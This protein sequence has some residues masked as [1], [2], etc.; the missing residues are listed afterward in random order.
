[1]RFLDAGASN[2][3]LSMKCCLE[4]TIKDR[5]R[6]VLLI[7]FTYPHRRSALQF[8]LAES[9]SGSEGPGVYL[10][11]TYLAASRPATFNQQNRVQ[12]SQ[13]A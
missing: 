3:T 5:R 1:M 9:H 13:I 6:F 4:V 7:R 8:R 10:A 12:Q 11:A 2:G